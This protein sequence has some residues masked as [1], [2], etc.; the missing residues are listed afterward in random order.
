MAGA[1]VT[2]G[3]RGI[4]AAIVRRLVKDGYAVA[5]TYQKEHEKARQISLETGALAICADAGDEDAVLKSVK[6]AEAH[7]GSIDVLVNNAAISSFRL[8]TEISREE[9]DRFLAVNL[10][11]PFLYARE[12]ARGMIG[13]KFGRIVNISSVWG[14]TGASCEVHYSTTKAGVIGLTK[15]LAKELGP[16]GITVN[17]VAP[18]VIDTDMNAVLDQSTRESLIEETPLC[19]IGTPEDVAAAVAF[20]VGTDAAFITGQILSPNGGFLI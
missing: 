15:A 20:L 14:V 2:G 16:S 13:R 4:G 11:A 6:E 10:T 1:L 17:C 7:L 12:C 18:G 9:W 3:A 19:K 8:F 5:F